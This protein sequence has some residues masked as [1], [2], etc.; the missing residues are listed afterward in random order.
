[1]ATRRDLLVRTAGAAL[2]VACPLPAA[3]R[4]LGGT[5]LALVTADRDAQLVAVD[6]GTGRI[7]GR[8]ATPPGPR[9]VESAWLTWAIVAHT[10]LGRLSIVHAP[11]L[12]VRHVVRGLEEPRYTA[13]SNPST[14]ATDRLVALVTDSGARAVVSLDVERGAVLARTRVPGPARHLSLSPDGTT[15]WV[16]LGS[17]ADTIAVLAVGEGGSTRVARLVRPPAPAHDVVFAPGGRH[18]WVTGGSGRSIWVY[19]AEGRKPVAELVA[20]APPQHVAWVGGRAFVASGEG[21]TVRVHRSDGALVDVVDVPLGSYNVTFGWQ[22]AVTPSLDRGTVTLLDP[23]GRVRATR[24]VARSAH[25]A[26]V[27]VGR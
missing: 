10:A 15:A 22:R 21:G 25:D 23:A 27:V 18:V 3:A 7:A 5:P 6:L 24:R 8:V 14:S 13:V 17:K 16:A 12:R 9:S 19:E 4:A 26:C 1:M 20:D 2:A 11:S